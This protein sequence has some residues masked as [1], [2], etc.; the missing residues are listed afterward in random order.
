MDSQCLFSPDEY[1]P[2]SSF[3][4]SEDYYLYFVNYFAYNCQNKRMCT[5]D[6]SFSHILPKS[7]AEFNFTDF[8]QPL[9]LMAKL[10]DSCLER[11]L[12]T[13]ITSQHFI[14]NIGCRE[15]DV[16]TPWGKR[17][18]K[19]SVGIVAAA[20]DIGSIFI[21]AFFFSKLQ[22]L[23]RE[24]LDIIDDMCVQMSDFSL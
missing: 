11:M 2:D 14:L 12:N 5:I 15:D 13:N 19:H 1:D 7:E 17:M 24:Y 23:N 22:T 6:P 4:K 20:L 8:E 10:S 9:D 3:F 18:H 16:A 21:M